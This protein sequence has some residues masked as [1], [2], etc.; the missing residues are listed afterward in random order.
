MNMTLQLY[1]SMHTYIPI[2]PYI[3]TYTYSWMRVGAFGSRAPFLASILSAK[4]PLVLAA[5]LL[6][7]L[8]GNT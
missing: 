6:L 1:V 7:S 5:G 3:S 2:C 8:A 4:E